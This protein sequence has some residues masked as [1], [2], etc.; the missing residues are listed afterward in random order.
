MIRVREIK[1][2]FSLQIVNA[3]HGEITGALPYRPFLADQALLQ[4]HQIDVCRVIKQVIDHRVDLR[5][6]L[7]RKER[8]VVEYPVALKMK[9]H[10]NNHD[11][12]CG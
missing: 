5:C 6:S 11:R 1:N 4:E 3:D 8:D 12:D 9:C 10:R 7:M 2:G